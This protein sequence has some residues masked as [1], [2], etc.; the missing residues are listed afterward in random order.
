MHPSPAAT[1]WFLNVSLP[2]FFFTGISFASLAV[3]VTLLADRL[4]ITITILLTL[5][6]YRF[7]IMDRLPNVDDLV[8]CAAAPEPSRCGG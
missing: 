5:V 8:R 7:A 1:Y 4:A 6:S 2:L 3:E